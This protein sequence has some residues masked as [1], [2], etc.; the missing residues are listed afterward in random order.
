MFRFEGLE[1]WKLAVEFG[2]ECYKLTD[3]FPKYENFGL[4]DQLRRAG[5]SI[6]NNITEGSVG[7]SANFKK[8]IITAIGS[9]LETV[10]I[11]NFSYE[12]G[13]IDLKTKTKMYEKAE[14]LIKKLH[15]FSRAIGN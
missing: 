2:K 4:S 7:S 14:R 3:T 10:N 6:S 15:S 11:L 12:I 5:V 9:T 1:V 13:Y 8:Y